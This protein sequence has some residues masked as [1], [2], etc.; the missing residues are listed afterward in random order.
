MTIA[1]VGLG[2]VGICAAVSLL[3]ALA[4]RKLPFRIVA[5]DILEARREKMKAVYNAIDASGKGN[6]EFEVLAVD[7]AKVLVNKWTG[8]IGCTAVLEVVG[9]PSALTSAYDLVRAFGVV[10][11]VGVHGEPAM[12]FT[13]RQLY[14]KNV[15]FDFGRCPARAMFPSAFDLLVKRQD[16]FGRVGEPASL[17]DRIVSLKEAAENYRAFDKG[18]VGKVIFSPWD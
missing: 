13:G 18:E 12:P 2:P 16:V 10:V 15:S 17:I 11:S 9:H 8:G 1:I 14:N 4:T 6:G 7:E 3:D 5:I